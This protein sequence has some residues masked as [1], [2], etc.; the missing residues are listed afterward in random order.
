MWN[1]LNGGGVHIN[2]TYKSVI[3]FN[4]GDVTCT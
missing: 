2:L 4:E 3:G 1:Y